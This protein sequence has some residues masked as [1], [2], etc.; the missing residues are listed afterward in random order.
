MEEGSG[1]VVFAQLPRG[2]PG[3]HHT[4]P[5]MQ[6]WQWRS[7]A[8]W[9]EEQHDAAGAR[10]GK[11]EFTSLDIVRQKRPRWGPMDE[12]GLRQWSRG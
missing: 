1:V 11:R 3:C 2:Q 4:S 5:W 9:G 10:L 12:Q 6:E 7:W 8:P